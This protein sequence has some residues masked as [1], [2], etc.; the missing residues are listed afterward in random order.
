MSAVY[1]IGRDH[2]IMKLVEKVGEVYFSI[3]SVNPSSGFGN[4][5]NDLFQ[6]FLSGPPDERFNTEDLD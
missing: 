1:G 5:F 4:M 3:R 6:S 2:Y